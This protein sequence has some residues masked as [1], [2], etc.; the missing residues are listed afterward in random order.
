MLK[1]IQTRKAPEAI[2]TYSQAV[3]AGN[4]LFISGQIGLEPSSMKL[5]KSFS[6]QAN[7]IFDNLGLIAEEAGSSR[8]SIVKLTVFLLTLD[9]FSELNQIM[10]RYFDAPYPARSAVGVSELPKGALI[11]VEAIVKIK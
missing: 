1:T 3:Y 6:E 8:N 7:Q 5:K 10:A 2:G 9:N 4:I 11:E